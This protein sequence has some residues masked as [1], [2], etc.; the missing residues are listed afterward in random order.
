MKLV[1]ALDSKSSSERSAGSTPATRTTILGSTLCCQFNGITQAQ[2][3]RANH[4]SYMPPQRADYGASNPAV[5]VF[6]LLWPLWPR[7]E[8]AR[9]SR[10]ASDPLVACEGCSNDS[11]PV[12]RHTGA[13][14]NMWALSS[15]IA[16]MSP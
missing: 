14:S 8:R 1:D 9:S 16:V 2:F 7:K 10:V 12:V 11:E 13:N 4:R 6:L 5:P 15:F 3:Y